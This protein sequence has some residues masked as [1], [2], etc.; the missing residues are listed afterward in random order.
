[1]QIKPVIDPKYREIEIHVCNDEHN[2]E[3]RGITTQ[4]HTLFD[5]RLTGVDEVGNR[6]MIRPAG[7]FTFYSQGQKVFAMDESRRYLISKKL[8]ELEEEYESLG[9]VRISKSEL[10]NYKRIKSLDLS[11][12][13]TI[14]VTMKNGYETYSS[15]RN[16]AKI[17]ELLCS[18]KKTGA[19]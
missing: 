17:K 13:G 14:K 10:V 19:K 18:E 12:T 15:R 6:C 8:Y 2:D 1:M 11:L 7:I 3:V 9:F 5:S 4:L 16:V